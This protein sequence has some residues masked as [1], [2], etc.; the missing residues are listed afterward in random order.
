MRALLP[1]LLLV[2]TGCAHL[3]GDSAPEAPVGRR[4]EADVDVSA[5]AK[6]IVVCQS[7]EADL[8]Q[9]LGPPTRDGL[10]HRER[11]LSWLTRDESPPKYLAVLLDRNGLVV[12]VYWDIPTE[13]PWV[14]TNHCVQGID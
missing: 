11:V 13:V 1:A 6:S 2:L 12:D 5:V 9:R 14:P 7:N 4:V 10:L 3:P 8:R